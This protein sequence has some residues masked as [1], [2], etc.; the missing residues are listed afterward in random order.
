MM[1]KIIIQVLAE[2]THQQNARIQNNTSAY[3]EKDPSKIAQT[4][5][6]PEPLPRRRCT[7]R[8]LAVNTPM[9]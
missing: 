6:D 9:E 8:T 3:F 1:C 4:T 7:L 5:F 2:L